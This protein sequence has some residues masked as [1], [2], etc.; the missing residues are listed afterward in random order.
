M[1]RTRQRSTRWAR[2]LGV[3]VV[4]LAVILAA[5]GAVP[6]PAVRRPVLR[7]VPA[8]TVNEGRQL[9]FALV[10]SGAS[11]R[12]L[13]FS[14]TGLPRGAHLDSVTG[15]F[16]WVP[17]YSQSGSYN[18]TFRV[19]DGR[20]AASQRCRITVHDVAQ[21]RGSATIF[22][23]VNVNPIALKM[24]APT[25]ARTER[26][27]F[28]TVTVRSWMDYP[29]REVVLHLV[30]P[31][32]MLILGPH[33]RQAVSL[34]AHGTRT[35]TWRVRAATPGHYVMLATADLPGSPGAESAA[36]TVLVKRAP[37]FLAW[38]LELLGALLRGGGAFE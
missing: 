31:R 12:A 38:L 10:A 5:T 30:V 16:T 29:V 7:P 21:R 9:R 22:A 25:T 6:R 14:A 18:V 15:V 17:T 26:P 32:G 36:R 4:G 37:T 35:V 24:K 13:I 2:R 3:L 33:T 11:S 20:A 28:V 34:P 23:T 27:F 8:R 1:T 19:R